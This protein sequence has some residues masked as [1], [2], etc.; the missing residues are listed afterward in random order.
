MLAGIILGK[1]KINGEPLMNFSPTFLIAIAVLTLVMVVFD[2]A[3]RFE[4]KV[5]NTLS[6]SALKV[7]SLFLIMNMI[8]VTLFT[9]FFFF[10]AITIETL[11]VS[12]LFAILMS[13]T[14]PGSV[15][16]MLKSTSNKV[17][18]LLE[19]ESILNTPIMVILPFIIVDI[20]NNLEI[21]SVTSAFVGQTIPLLRQIVVGIGAGMI[22]GIV[23][24]KSMK[25]VYSQRFSPVGIITAALLAYI[26]AENLDGNGVL[27]VATLGLF[28][29]NIYVKEKESLQEFNSMLSNSL[30]VLVFILIGLIIEINFDVS[31]L[32]RALVLFGIIILCR[33]VAVYFALGKEEF[34]LKEK[35]FMALSMPKGIAVA[36]VAFSLT[37]FSFPVYVRPMI[38]TILQLIIISMIYSLVLTTVV[39]KFSKWFIRIK[40]E[41]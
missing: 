10:D 16:I 26:L 41:K 36:V 32:F 17:I 23:I 13:G 34:N 6:I 25:K 19:V 40:I 15:F 24:F 1:I 21:S 9:T 18:N 28:F 30:V 29:G 39:D 31:F 2:G 20:L 35:I 8:F 5:V 4:L 11:L 22:I 27:A 38:D 33:L 7:S 12:L 3:S 37:V 14:D